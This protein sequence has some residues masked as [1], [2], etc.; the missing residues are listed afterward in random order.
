MVIASDEIQWSPNI[1]KNASNISRTQKL[2][3]ERPNLWLLNQTWELHF[4][5]KSAYH[6]LPWLHMDQDPHFLFLYSV[7]HTEQLVFVNMGQA[8]LSWSI[9]L[10]S[11]WLHPT[12]FEMADCC[13][14]TTEVHRHWNARPFNRGN[15]LYCEPSPYCTFANYIVLVVLSKRVLSAISNTDDDPYKVARDRC[16]PL[17][18][19]LSVVICCCTAITI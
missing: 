15:E 10:Y 8:T 2:R 9:Y 13:F 7:Y 17:N 11:L 18:M 19:S 12:V 14:L 1:S 16:L 4:R 5:V 3:T 6:A